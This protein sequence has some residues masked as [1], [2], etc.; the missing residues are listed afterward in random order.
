LEL[1]DGIG[2]KEDKER[3]GENC[4]GKK[5]LERC[6]CGGPMPPGGQKVK[7]NPLFTSLI[8]HNH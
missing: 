1:G 5:G 2:D 3:S 8:T 4:L 7:K 6:G